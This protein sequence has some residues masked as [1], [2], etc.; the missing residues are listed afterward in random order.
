MRSSRAGA[1]AA[2]AL[3]LASCLQ[4]A[5]EQLQPGCPDSEQGRALAQAA[6]QPQ[7]DTETP[8]LFRKQ[9]L[10]VCPHGGGEFDCANPL[11]YRWQHFCTFDR[12]AGGGWAAYM[13]CDETRQQSV[14]D[15]YR[16]KRDVPN[17]AAMLAFSPCDL[18]PLI[19][20]R[21][22]WV[23]GD[24]HSYDLYHALAC[25]LGG[26]WDYQFE[27]PLPYAGEEAAFA[28]LAAHVEHYKPP[29]CLPLA[30]GTLVCQV[31][32]LFARQNRLP[33]LCGMSWCMPC[34]CC[35]AHSACMLGAQPPC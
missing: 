1:A 12:A 13:V 5:G 27:G 31:R 15:Y 29:E 4:A 7:A 32:V 35:R 14:V 2:V 34:A 8:F 28:H 6:A 18:W 19:R 9:A 17:L 10:D 3:L 30:E 23:V 20:G 24:S 25:F 26:L 22:L 11:P 33:L 21:T 16:S